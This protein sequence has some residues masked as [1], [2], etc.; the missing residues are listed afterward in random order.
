MRQLG[1]VMGIAVMGAVLQNRA[2]AYAEGLVA[3]KL[4]GVPFVPYTTK[5][6]IITAV[7]SSM[8]NMGE[9][10]HAMRTTFIVAIV[11]LA[12]GSLVALL[13]RSHVAKTVVPAEEGPLEDPARVDQ[14]LRRA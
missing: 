9:F 8:T 10:V 2:V 4:A 1:S 12:V 14:A 7:G 11:V 5:Q 6:Q 3:G 13:I